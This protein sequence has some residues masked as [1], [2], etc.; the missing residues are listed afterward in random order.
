MHAAG[1]LGAPNPTQ[2]ITPEETPD[3]KQLWDN[4]QKLLSASLLVICESA[5]APEHSW[6]KK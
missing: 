2:G 4:L 6:N 3:T 1:E 5:P